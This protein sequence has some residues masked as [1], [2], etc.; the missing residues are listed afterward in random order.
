MADERGSQ[1]ALEWNGRLSYDGLVA[2]V[3]IVL[4]VWSNMIRGTGIISGTVQSVAMTFWVWIKIVIVF[5]HIYSGHFSI[6]LSLAVVIIQPN[7]IVTEF[8]P[9]VKFI[10]NFNIHAYYLLYY[11]FI[12]IT[13]SNFKIYYKT[14]FTVLNIT[15]TI[16]FRPYRMFLG[17]FDFT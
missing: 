1:G 8:C 13:R 17:W 10:W 4:C 3:F 5:L 16:M 2:S 15:K 12:I 11:F 6:T 14:L 9:G 7:L